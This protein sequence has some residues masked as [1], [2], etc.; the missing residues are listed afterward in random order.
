M[1]LYSWVGDT[2]LEDMEDYQARRVRC[3]RTCGAVEDDWVLPLG[4][5][6]LD[7]EFP[8]VGGAT[9]RLP[10]SLGSADPAPLVKGGTPASRLAGGIDA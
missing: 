2:Q 9:G 8:G 7:G 5:P 6:T 10:L 1:G 3:C 4:V